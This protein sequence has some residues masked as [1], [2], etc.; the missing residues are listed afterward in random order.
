M[1]KSSGINKYG[2][3]LAGGGGTRLWPKS[4][5]SL[6]KQFMNLGPDRTLLQDTFCRLRKFLNKE[7]IFI[8][9]IKNYLSEVKKELP[10]VREENILIEPSSKNTA[11]SIALAVWEISKICDNCVIGS[12]ASDHLIKNEKRFIEILET[13]YAAS[14]NTSDIITIGIPPTKADDGLGYVHIGSQILEV[15]SMPIFKVQRFLEKPDMALAK[16]FYASG[17][18]FWN[19]S[20]F[21]AKASTFREAYKTHLPDVLN[22]IKKMD[23]LNQK[24]KNEIWENLKNIAVDYGIMEKSSNISMVTGDFGWSDIGNW[25]VLSEVSPKSANGNVLLGDIDKKTILIDSKNCLVYGNGKLIALVGVS[26]LIIVEDKD[27]ILVTTKDKVQKVKQV[28]EKLKSEN[29]NDFL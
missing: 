14:E 1:K 23:G 27:A 17:E 29:K 7:N 15:N 11:A 16:A 4:R 12:F 28:V 24:Q 18:Y 10:E 26:D 13:A 5:N 22:V 8:V 3:I 9:T 6:P 20:Y 19:A 25:A 21:V 2:V